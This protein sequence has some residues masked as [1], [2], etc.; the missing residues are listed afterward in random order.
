MRWTPAD[1]R[2][3]A[4]VRDVLSRR[5]NNTTLAG[6]GDG[7]GLAV[8]LRKDGTF[9]GDFT[10]T[11]QSAEHSCAE[12]GFMLLGEHQSRGYATEAARELLAIA[13]EV[14]Q[15]HRVVARVEPRNG[16][17]CRVLERL[18][19][20]REGHFVENEWIKD[21]WQSEYSYAILADEWLARA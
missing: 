9:V 16:A 5:I 6:D 11:L 20:R 18:G 15:L 1:P 17:S 7:I 12:I 21:E 2:S 3:P 4:Q 10:L 8:V 14:L 19:M 13:F